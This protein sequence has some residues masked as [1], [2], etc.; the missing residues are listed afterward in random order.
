MFVGKKVIR[1]LNILF[2][3]LSGFVSTGLSAAEF[4]LSDYGQL[5]KLRAVSLSPNASKYAYLSTDSGQ[6]T[7]FVVDTKTGKVLTGARLG[8]LKARDVYFITEN[9]VIFTASETTQV[10]GYRGKFES[11]A[12]FVMDLSSKKVKGLL[13]KTTSLYPAQAGL[14]KIVGFKASDNIVYMPA[15]SKSPSSLEPPYDLYRVT[16]NRGLGKV[17]K[18]GNSSTI[19]WF[20]DKD[21]KLLA[22][23]DYNDKRQEHKI[24]SYISGKRKLVYEASASQLSIAIEAISA[25]EK[26]LLFRSDNRIQS[27]S[28]ED[29]SINDSVYNSD[30]EGAQVEFLKTDLNR[31]L[32]SVVYSGLEPFEV[33]ADARLE[34]VYSALRANLAGSR[35]SLADVDEGGKNL[36][37]RV[38]GNQTSGAYLM[39]NTETGVTSSLGKEYPNVM[40][41]D[42]G[43]ISSYYFD[44]RD[45][46]SIPSVLTWPTGVAKDSKQKLPL[47]VLPHGGPA[48]YDSVEFDWWAQFLARKG[49]L[50]LQPNFR[51]SSG[52]GSSHLRAGDREWGQAMQ[53]DVSDGVLALVEAGYA[54]PERVCIMGAS[55]GGYSALAGAAFSP[56][57]YRCVVSV[58][59]VSDL[60][61]MLYDSR[62]E[63]GSDH[64][65][66]RYWKDTIGD[67]KDEREMLSQVS[68]AKYAEKIKVPVLLIHGKDDTVVPLR[69]STIMQKALRKAGNQSELVKLKGEDHWLSKGETRMSMLEAI[70]QFLN[71]HNP[72]K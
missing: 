37:I 49:Y 51:G 16:L 8:D 66:N 63:F 72:A 25:D 23:E 70:D 26:S 34:K 29:G 69:Q 28:L 46:L 44:A 7:F 61:K 54:D 38:S 3:S 68:P 2:I 45:G 22:R 12:S 10:F 56:E 18:S 24:F 53:K 11:S 47:V 52:F 17:Y 55:Y 39:Y 32:L 13:N 19:D 42:I 59:G 36:V 64:W 4:S 9:Y 21:G 15:Y 67:L 65:V 14:G 41:S 62:S 30:I 50:V 60:P 43:Q 31:K 71:K 27:L 5:P 48:S 6:Q 35:V 1:I 57:L 20:L 58:A 40:Q 33:L